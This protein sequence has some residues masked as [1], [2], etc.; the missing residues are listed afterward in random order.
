MGQKGLSMKYDMHCHL[1]FC[2]APSLLADQLCAD[3]VGGL[4]VT[5][6]PSGFLRAKEA[7]SKVEGFQTAAGLHPWWINPDKAQAR[8]QVAALLE[9]LQTTRFVGEIGLDTSAHAR[10]S[11]EVQVFVF[12]QIIRACARQG[13]YVLSLHGVKAVGVM[14]DEIEAS[15]IMQDN[16][17]IFHWF[18]GSSQD[19]MRAIKLGCRFSVNSRMLA[20]GKGKEYA[21]VVPLDALL[22][23][24]DLPQQQSEASVDDLS[25]Q[26][27]NALS[28]AFDELARIKFATRETEDVTEE[29]KTHLAQTIAKQSEGLLE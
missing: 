7:L 18:S 24:T 28:V 14:L 12:R 23:E 20:S 9:V 10:A 25:A 5:V 27:K 22:L 16:S 6:E 21:K 2:S 1:D 4:S 17:C 13:G 19:L 3:G 11:L 8:L 26:M 15:G 29:Q